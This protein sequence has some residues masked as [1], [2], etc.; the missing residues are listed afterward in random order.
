MLQF[1]L[2]DLSQAC[3]V[4]ELNKMSYSIHSYTK[5]STFINVEELYS[6]YRL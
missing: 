5:N 2:D 4:H 1:Y 6:K 3:I